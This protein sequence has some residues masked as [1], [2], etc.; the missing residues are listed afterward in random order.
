MNDEVLI[1]IDPHKAHNTP[2]VIDPSSRVV[3]DGGEFANTQPGY[4][5]LM[6]FVRSWRC[7]RWTVEGLSRGGPV[8]GPCLPSWQGPSSMPIDHYPREAKA[9]IGPL[10]PLF[11]H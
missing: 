2:A 1:P 11:R 7:R 5:E 10:V 6:V 4:R 9:V 8:A 3:V